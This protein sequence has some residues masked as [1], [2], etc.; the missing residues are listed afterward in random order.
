MSCFNRSRQCSLSDFHQFDRRN[1]LVER[2]A[3][4]RRATL[5]SNRTTTVT[6]L[7]NRRT[8][9][10]YAYDKDERRVR[11]PADINDGVLTSSLDLHV[12]YASCGVW[13]ERKRSGRLPGGGARGT[14]VNRGRGC[15]WRVAPVSLRALATTFGTRHS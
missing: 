15:C 12:T 11:Y 8:R 2:I 3:R 6:R 5:P 14:T 13:T 10:R 9:T 4:C 1:D 7:T